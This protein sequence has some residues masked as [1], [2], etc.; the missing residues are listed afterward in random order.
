MEQDT[1]TRGMTRRRSRIRSL[2]EQRPMSVTELTV[3][4]GF[5]DPRSYIRYLRRHGVRVQDEWRHGSE[6]SRYKV[7]YIPTGSANQKQ[8]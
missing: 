4:T 5:C 3:A 7:Y 1:E 2:L 8:S 6:G